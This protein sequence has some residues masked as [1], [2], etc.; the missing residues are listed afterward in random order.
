M[1]A[2]PKTELNISVLMQKRIGVN[3]AYSV[4]LPGGD[5]EKSLLR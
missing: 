1:N 2:E 5:I 4:A 3:G